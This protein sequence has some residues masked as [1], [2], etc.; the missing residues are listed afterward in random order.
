MFVAEKEIGYDLEI[1]EN[2]SIEE[3][4]KRYWEG[5]IIW[6]NAS[7]TSPDGKPGEYRCAMDFHGKVKYLEKELPGATANQAM[8]H[9]AIDAVAC[10]QK[11]VRVFIC[12]PVA[13]GYE[14]AF[15]GKGV[16]SGLMQELFKLLLK[17]GCQVTEVQFIGGADLIKKFVLSCNPDHTKL[18]RAIQKEQQGRDYYRAKIYGECMEKVV[19]VLRKNHIDEAI[20]REV[21]QI[22]PSDGGLG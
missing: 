11:P 13:L 10:I 8:I 18:D 12:S 17:K 2:M 15:K 16:N 20:I 5:I 14:S 22:D 3:L 19:A 9:G 4:R 6:L 7:G 21:M 1:Q